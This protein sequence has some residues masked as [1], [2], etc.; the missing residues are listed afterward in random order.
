MSSELLPLRRRAV[1]LVALL[2]LALGTSASCGCGLLGKIAARK[3]D[4]AETQKKLV[5]TWVAWHS[6]L[7][8]VVDLRADG[9]FRFVLVGESVADVTGKWVVNGKFLDLNVEKIVDGDRARIGN[10]IRW[11]IE[12]IE[13]NEVVLGGSNGDTTYTRQPNGK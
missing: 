1:R 12:K 13:A 6:K 3:E 4:D 9:T 7:T 2:A 11:S 8:E 5:G 10:L